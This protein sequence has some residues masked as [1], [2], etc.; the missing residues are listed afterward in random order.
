MFD[1][2]LEGHCCC[3]CRSRDLIQKA[4]LDN[5]YMKHLERE[6][7]RPTRVCAGEGCFP[8]ETFS[9]SWPRVQIASIVDSM[10]PTSLDKGS[11]VTQEGDVGS[12]LYVL[13]GQHALSI[14]S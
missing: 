10:Y 1:R 2:Q 12:T 11:C 9:H 5:D 6:Q 14:L 13:E 7:V 8:P 4:L 3:V